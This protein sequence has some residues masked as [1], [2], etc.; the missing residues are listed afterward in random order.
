MIQAI[1]ITLGIVVVLC[2]IGGLAIKL[3][4][5]DCG[6]VLAIGMT[7][8][9]IGVFIGLFGVMNSIISE[10]DRKF[11]KSEFG[12]ERTFDE[13]FWHGDDI[14]EMVIGN[15]IRVKEEK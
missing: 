10:S 5:G 11:I 6:V 15:T 9:I 1:L 2:A 7:L 8:F 4:D 13:M 12:V 14:K 3:D